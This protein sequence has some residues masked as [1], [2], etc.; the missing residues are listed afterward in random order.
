[1]PFALIAAAVSN[2][3]LVAQ[4]PFYAATFVVQCVFYAAAVA[5][6]WSRSR[7]LRVPAFF[8]LSNL[9]VLVAWFRYLRGDRITTWTPSER[10]STLP[11][12]EA[13]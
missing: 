10:T 4:S 1:M 8:L 5:G 6:L 7:F 3:L 12:A 11:Q 9:A 2:A 13:R